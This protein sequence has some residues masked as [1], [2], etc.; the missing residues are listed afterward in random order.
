MD[1]NLLNSS[2]ACTRPKRRQRNAGGTAPAKE[3]AGRVRGVASTARPGAV[4]GRDD[5]H[6]VHQRALV[7]GWGNRRA[8][9]G[10]QSH[11]HPQPFHERG[12]WVH[13]REK[14][15]ELEE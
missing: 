4:I 7:A 10:P 2:A 9:G 6:A 13:A 15:R 14:E 11:G 1:V 3:P 12:A 8:E 5:E